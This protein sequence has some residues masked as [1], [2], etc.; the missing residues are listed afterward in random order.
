[1]ILLC[2]SAAWVAWALLFRDAFS[3]RLTGL[4]LAS[5]GGPAGRWRGAARALLVWGPLAG[6]LAASLWLGVWRPEQA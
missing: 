3:Y 5:Q 1:V 4:T 6:L 2:W